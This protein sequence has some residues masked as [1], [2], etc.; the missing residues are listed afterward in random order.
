MIPSEGMFTLAAFCWRHWERDASCHRACS[1][2]SRGGRTAMLFSSHLWRTKVFSVT[3]TLAI[4]HSLNARG[5]KKLSGG[6]SMCDGCGRFLLSLSTQRAQVTACK[7]VCP[8]STTDSQRTPARPLSPT[9]VQPQ[10]LLLL[11]KHAV[12]VA[13]GGLEGTEGDTKALI[14]VDG[15]PFIA[16]R[17]LKCFLSAAAV[18]KD[19]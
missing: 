8:V 5:H 16:Y 11:N 3:S 1:V 14:C 7:Q 15:A 9:V 10:H 18:L 6:G 12:Y 2:E 19:L 4:E 13:P 17:E